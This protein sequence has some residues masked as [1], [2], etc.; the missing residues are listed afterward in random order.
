ML[1]SQRSTS[2]LKP[3]RT[4]SKAIFP[5]SAWSSYSTPKRSINTATTSPVEAEA[6]EITKVADAVELQDQIETLVTVSTC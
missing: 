5:T 2:S 6:E 1:T 3:S 4:E